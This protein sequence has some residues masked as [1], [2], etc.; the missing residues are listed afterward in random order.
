MNDIDLDGGGGI[1]LKRYNE[2]QNL[3]CNFGGIGLGLN[4][5]EITLT[6]IDSMNLDDVGYIHCDAQ[7]SE[8]FIFSKGIDTIKKFKPLIYYENNELYGRYLHDNVCN[9]YPQYRNE[10]LFDIKKYCMEEL[11]YSKYIDRFNG[12]VDTLL[13]P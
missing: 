5:E 8:N 12:G 4:G 7:G 13:I 2:E 11:N 10:K 6:T 1:V 3:N 9:S